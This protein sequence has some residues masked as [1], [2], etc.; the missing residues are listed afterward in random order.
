MEPLVVLR[1][2]EESLQDLVA[3][4]VV[5]V[6][7]ISEQGCAKGVNAL[8]VH[9][10]ELG[11]TEVHAAHGLFQGFGSVEAI[12]VHQ[13]LFSDDVERGV[14]VKHPFTFVKVFSKELH[15]H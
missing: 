14:H 3:V 11:T 13:L 15:G 8:A 6:E 5:L 12:G 9:T 10:V 7:A 2:S 1:A 4:R